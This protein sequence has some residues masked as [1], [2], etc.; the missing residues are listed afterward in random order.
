MAVFSPDGRKVAF[1]SLGDGN[2]EIYVMNADG[3]G[4]FRLTRNKAEDTY[5]TFSADGRGVIFS[6]NREGKF[7]IYQVA[8]PN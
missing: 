2:R 4:L 5:P 8:L 7:Q 3:S 6:S 1:T